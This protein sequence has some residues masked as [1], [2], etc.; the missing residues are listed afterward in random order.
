MGSMG[1]TW[2]QARGFLYM[3]WQWRNILFSYIWSMY[4]NGRFKVSLSTSYL[5]LPWT[6][7]FPKSIFIFCKILQRA[8]IWSN[9]SGLF[10]LIILK[11]W[12]QADKLC[13][14]FRIFFWRMY[15]CCSHFSGSLTVQISYFFKLRNIWT[16]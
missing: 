5:R 4:G 6:E 1:S 12:L 11:E 10:I 2:L 14:N 13:H 16:L 9:M 15:C 8:L 3:A 7:F